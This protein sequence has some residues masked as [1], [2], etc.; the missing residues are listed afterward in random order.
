MVLAVGAAQ[1]AETH[2][3]RICSIAAIAELSGLPAAAVI[4]DRL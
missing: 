2:D 1:W 4:N 3:P